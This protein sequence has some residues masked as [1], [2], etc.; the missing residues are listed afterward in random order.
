MLIINGILLQISATD[1]SIDNSIFF[2]HTLRKNVASFNLLLRKCKVRSWDDDISNSLSSV[3][4]KDL[5]YSSLWHISYCIFRIIMARSNHDGN[6][7]NSNI[8]LS[9]LLTAYC[10]ISEKMP[11]I[12]SDTFLRSNTV[13]RNVVSGVQSLGSDLDSATW[14]APGPSL[15]QEW[16]FLFHTAAVRWWWQANHWAVNCI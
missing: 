3:G 9:R 4:K 5:V 11:V 6:D 2:I 7:L 14:A 10:L 15:C 8:H 1:I 13:V 16:Q 12:F